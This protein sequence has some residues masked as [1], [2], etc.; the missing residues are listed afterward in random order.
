MTTRNAFVRWAVIFEI[1]L[2]GCLA[3]AG[4]QLDQHA[5]AEPSL[6]ELAREVT[7][8][9]AREHLGNVPLFTNDNLPRSDAG[10]GVIG[11]TGSAGQQA[12]RSLAAQQEPAEKR[13]LEDLR[14]KLSQAQQK[15]Q[16]HQRELVVLE[17]KLSQS[18]MQYYPNPNET[19]LQEYS[20]QD[21]NR[22]TEKI[23][24]KK[25]QVADDQ[26]AVDNLQSALQNAEARWGW[27]AAAQPNNQAPTPPPI[28]A[29]RGSPAYWRASLARARQQL[30]TA[31]EQEK[32][33][34]DELSLL[35]IQQIRTIDPNLQA[36]FA[37]AISAKQSELTAAQDAV[38]DAQNNLERIEEKMK[39]ESRN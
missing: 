26:Q 14:Y 22:L 28:A 2:A 30:T 33:A 15:L 5:V 17:A 25:Q 32:L 11:S 20:R 31:K 6:G 16:I 34:R 27:L 18:S 24:E 37:S 29:Q 10:L 8:Q 21:I 36:G 19:L 38:R 35:R 23:Y 4:D 39:A 13:Q 3:F 12:A 7:A 1:L 9:R